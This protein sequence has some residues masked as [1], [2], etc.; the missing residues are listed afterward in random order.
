MI[1]NLWSLDYQEYAA[2]QFCDWHSAS[3]WLASVWR[4]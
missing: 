1:D 2:Q 4:F 3:R